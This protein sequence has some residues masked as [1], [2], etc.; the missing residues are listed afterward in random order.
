[1]STINAKSTAVITGASSGIG[2][3]YAD[4][5]AARG[6]DLVLVARRAGRLETLA[7]QLAKDH[8][9][10]VDVIDAD[11]TKDADLSRVEQVLAT[12]PRVSMLVNNAGNGKL[13]ATIDMAAADLASTVALNITALAR[14]TRAVLPA[15][16]ARN[17]GAIINISSVMALQSLSITSLY[18]GTKG[19]VL[20]FSRGLHEELAGTGV[21][22]QAVLPAG[23][24]TEFYDHAGIP[25]SAFDPAVVMS[26]ENMVDAALA[27]FDQG[28]TVTLPS[29]HDGHLWKAYDAARGQL[30]AATQNGTPAPRYRAA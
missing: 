24:A 26:A 28:E 29:V 18:S 10:R 19:F 4:R 21:R 22:V 25:L 20:N 13:G 6:Y 27:G 16:L 9:V 2:A 5:L 8:G 30:F 15:L 23:T 12:D 3:V 14:L 11:L 1:M 17:A 7:T